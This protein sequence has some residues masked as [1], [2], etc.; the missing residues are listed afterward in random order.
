[1]KE[2][3]RA[4]GWALQALYAWESRGGA[5]EDLMP[6]LEELDLSPRNRLHAEVLLRIILRKKEEVDGAIERH[7]TNW[8]LA[9]L[10][11]LDRNILRIGVAELLFIE[12]VPPDVTV[13][14]MMRLANAYGTAE[15]P[16]FVR[17]VLEAII[18]DRDQD[19]PQVS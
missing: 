13:R 3:A 16:R 4:R 5:G 11:V 19:A 15:S 17:G 8:T 7:L 18:A 9:R 12:D 10:A 2:R 14:E 6:I 1:M